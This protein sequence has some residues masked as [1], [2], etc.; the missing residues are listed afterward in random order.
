MRSLFETIKYGFDQ[1]WT[2]SQT[3]D[4]CQNEHL[5]RF[6]ELVKY[7]FSLLGRIKEL[8]Q[9]IPMVLHCPQCN[10][11]HI[12]PVELKPHKTH[13]CQDCGTLFTPSLI[14]TTG[15]KF[16]PGCKN[17]YEKESPVKILKKIIEDANT[18]PPSNR[19]SVLYWVFNQ[20]KKSSL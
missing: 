19:R 13:A 8:E 12:D 16:L 20:F 15:I 7:V 18:L 1:E 6:E 10:T 3:S 9:P 2:P 17:E 11:R 4:L 5:E 14:H